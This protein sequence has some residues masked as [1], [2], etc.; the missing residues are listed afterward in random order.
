VIRPV[1]MSVEPLDLR[2]YFQGRA[3]RA[4][5]RAAHDLSIPLAFDAAQPN[6]F[7]APPATATALTAGSFIGEVRRGGS[8]NCATYSLTPHCNGTHTECVGH[9]TANLVAIRNIA[10]PT[11]MPARLVTLEPV[12]AADSHE[13]SDPMPQAEDSLMTRAALEHALGSDTLREVGAL[14]VRSLPNEATKRH[15][16]YG[17]SAALPAYFTREFMG[18]IVAQG[19][20]HLIVDLPSIDRA[21]DEGRLTAHRIFFGLPPGATDASL[22]RRAQAT[23]TELAYI[24]DAIADGWYALN[25]QVAPFMTDAAPSRP[26]ILPL[27][28]V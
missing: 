16:Q 1:A 15:R 2:L 3:W 28:P 21:E 7:G 10:V 17:P 27:V 9:L 12:A 14:I 26:V 8:C 13:T 25:L 23:V 22:A 24:D 11:L 18:F 19:I 6:F 4:N 20:E 5:P